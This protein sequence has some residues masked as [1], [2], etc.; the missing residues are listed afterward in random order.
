VR[1]R[2]SSKCAGRLHDAALGAGR[3]EFSLNV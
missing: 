2:Q 3:L 1:P